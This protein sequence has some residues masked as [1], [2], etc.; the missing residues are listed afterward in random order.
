DP[1][2]I[3]VSADPGDTSFT[4]I[5]NVEPV[6]WN[7]EEEAPW[8]TVTRIND[9][10][11]NIHY[12]TNTTTIPRTASINAFVIYAE[13]SKTVV[14]SQKGAAAY[15]NVSPDTINVS[16]AA[17]S[18]SFA[19]TSNIEWS[20]SEDSEW[21]SAFR[22]NDTLVTVEYNENP[23]EEY[24]FAL[25]TLSGEGVS[26]ETVYI[27][28]E[29]TIVGVII[30]LSYPVR[31]TIYPNPS[32]GKIFLRTGVEIDTETIISLFNKSGKL[33]YSDKLDKILSREIIV[34]DISTFNHGVY[35]LHLKNSKFIV[36]EK[37]I[38]Y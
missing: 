6:E 9:S 20:M 26:T 30:D 21:L 31:L 34:I 32:S 12:D 5:T 1:D 14:I 3:H 28:Q 8:L 35:I 11:I 18:T 38:K 13:V 27:E 7:I 37:I 25:I 24:R 19:V 10:I 36:T 16:S 23:N 17:G 15:L 4:V 22:S 29:G 2:S 33:L